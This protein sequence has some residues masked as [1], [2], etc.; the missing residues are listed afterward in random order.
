PPRGTAVVQLRVQTTRLHCP[1][2]VPATMLSLPCES[3][4]CGG[5]ELPKQDRLPAMMFVWISSAS[6]SANVLLFTETLPPTWFR[7]SPNQQLFI[8]RTVMLPPTQPSSK[9]VKYGPPKSCEPHW[10]PPPP[11][12]IRTRPSTRSPWKI[13]N[14]GAAAIT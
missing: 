11:P 4:R 8:R 2:T 6:G 13:M 5:G 14:A 1:L 3:P 12:L 10:T 9:V 7:N